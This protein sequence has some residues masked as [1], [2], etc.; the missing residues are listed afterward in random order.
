MIELNL[1]ELLDS[2]VALKEL[3]TVSFPARVAFQFARIC[4]E[5]QK[6]NDLFET[7]RN[8]LIRK[9]CSY[10]ENGAIL[11]N[12]K[13]YID[14]TPENQTTFEKELGALLST[15]VQLNVE[16]ISVEDLGDYQISP[17]QMLKIMPFLK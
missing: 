11:Y 4:R 5:V 8:D 1:N 9:Y 16:S 10:D 13:G 14:F 12:D 6:E 15:K 17:E 2:M 3:T 7:Q